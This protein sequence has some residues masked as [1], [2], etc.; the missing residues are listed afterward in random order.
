MHNKALFQS[1]TGYSK[2]ARRNSNIMKNESS[3]NWHIKYYTGIEDII[4]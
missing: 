2:I 4:I 1:V 3:L